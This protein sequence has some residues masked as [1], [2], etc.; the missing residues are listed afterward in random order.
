MLMIGDTVYHVA[1]PDIPGKITGKIISNSY[2][3]GSYWI[4]VEFSEEVEFSANK[5]RKSNFWNCSTHLL[6]S[7]SEEARKNHNPERAKIYEVR[8]EG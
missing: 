2:V 3:D 6:F 1:H 8:N 4:P 5:G 7:S